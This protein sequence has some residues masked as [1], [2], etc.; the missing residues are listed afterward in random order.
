MTHESR[1]A[2]YHLPLQDAKREDSQKEES[3]TEEAQSAFEITLCD[4]TLNCRNFNHQEKYK[5]LIFH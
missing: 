3:Q 2:Q 4:I 1:K 5:S